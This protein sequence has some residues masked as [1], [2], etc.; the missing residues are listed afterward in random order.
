MAEPGPRLKLAERVAELARELGIETALIGAA[1]LAVHKYVRATGDL[2]LA[3][4]VD[5]GHLRR[6]QDR[7]EA[8]RLQC[9]LRMPDEEDPLGGVLE[10]WE[11]T[12]EDGDPI[13]SIEI[14]N[15]VNPYR[16][17]R[18]TP[19]ADA[20]RD[21]QPVDAAS[22][23]RCVQLP[24]L[25][26]LKLYAGG[27]RDRADVAELLARNPDA[28]LEAIRATCRRHALDATLEQLIAEARGP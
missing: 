15:F 11:H 16:P 4:H 25:I 14:V 20:I 22:A 18:V 24:D 27:L 6:L 21:A 17:G 28:D 2:D 12:N 19:A 7:L 9:G 3:T 10:V 23:L 5:P 13:D 8:T 26:A 1:A